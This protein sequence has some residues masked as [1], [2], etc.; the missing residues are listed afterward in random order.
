LARGGACVSQQIAGETYLICEES[1]TWE[2]AR[3]ACEA[4]CARLV[5]LDE[6]ESAELVAALRAQMTDED[7]KQEQDG[8]DQTV[9]PRASWW[10]G[11]RKVNGEY[12]WLDGAPMP[13]KGT[14]GW[15]SNDP[16]IAGDDAC[17]VLGVF[18]KG[19]DNGK[20]FDRSCKDV[21]YRSICEPL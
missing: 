4:R 8:G 12:L 13:P 9:W 17:A 1:G 11:G 20:W 18:G 6:V 15:Y 3:A 10:L 5:I 7:I 2:Q 14:G 19:D 16:D 21:A